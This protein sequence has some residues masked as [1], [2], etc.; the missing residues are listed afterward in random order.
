MDDMAKINLRQMI[1]KRQKRDASCVDDIICKRV[2]VIVIVMLNA[3]SWAL[4]IYIS[5]CGVRDSMWIEC[6]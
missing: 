1:A 4:N 5:M 2:G 6:E 3:Q